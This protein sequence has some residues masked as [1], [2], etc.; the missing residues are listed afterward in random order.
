M[1]VTNAKI[2]YLQYQISAVLRLIPLFKLSEALVTTRKTG[3]TPRFALEPIC[4]GGCTTL[5]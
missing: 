2:D 1:F 5:M 4:S 3:V